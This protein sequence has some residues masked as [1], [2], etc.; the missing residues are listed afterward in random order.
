LLIT[1]YAGGNQKK[2][3][4]I[5]GNCNAANYVTGVKMIKKKTEKVIICYWD[6]VCILL[7][8]TVFD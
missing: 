3:E 2:K 8:Y 5:Q 4:A 7:N 1:V 6:S